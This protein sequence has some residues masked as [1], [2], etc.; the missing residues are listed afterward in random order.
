MYTTY[1]IV[2]L[3]PVIYARWK[4]QYKAM[5]SSLR[6]QVTFLHWGVTKPKEDDR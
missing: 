4:K 5:F 6:L 2:L 1:Q 3:E